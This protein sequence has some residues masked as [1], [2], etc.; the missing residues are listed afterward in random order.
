MESVKKVALTSGNLKG[1][2]VR[3]LKD[4]AETIK[5]S[6]VELRSRTMTEEVARLEAANARLA[7]ELVEVRNEMAQ[8]RLQRQQD[9]APVPTP[10]LEEIARKVMV[11][12]GAM[13]NARLEGLEERLLP[14]KRLRPPLASDKKK[15]LT[16][17]AIATPAAAASCSVQPPQAKKMMDVVPAVSTKKANK[18]FP[19]P[20]NNKNKEKPKT[21]AKESRP[22]PPPPQSM[23][24]GWNVV[25]RRGSKN[26]QNKKKASKNVSNTHVAAQKKKKNEL[27]KL[28]PPRSA[29][30]VL[31]L[32]P[33]AV[34]HG[35]TYSKVLAD[36]RQHINLKDIG[37]EGVKFRSTAT[38][39][40]LLEVPGATSAGNANALA[41]KLRESLDK[42]VVLISRPEK[43]VEL[44]ITG[45][46][47]SA[48]KEDV[49]AAVAEVGGCTK[50][51]I[52]AGDVIRLPNR[53]DGTIWLR[54]PIA[55]AK[56]ATE[57]RLLVGWVSVQVK[58]LEPRPLRCFRCLEPGHM[59]IQCTS[60]ID[61]SRLCFC[62][63]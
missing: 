34:E 36:A 5:V 56:K 57:R 3:A 1:T 51:A 4:A 52:K 26:K 39:A 30:V 20:Q 15:S 2:Y 12:C 44:H 47:D 59:G 10:T 37:I 40:R 24:E 19:E 58:I 50:E 29:A 62:C 45:L 17:P 9:L 8:M 32:W 27:P 48:T 23:D 21:A 46:D 42:E 54:C 63:G 35:I 22:L 60:D 61:R 25:T 53:K 6:F 7:S 41:E 33:D 31:T 43:C 14:E 11:E 13:M 18:A 55:A 49:I 28:R 38:G 16:V